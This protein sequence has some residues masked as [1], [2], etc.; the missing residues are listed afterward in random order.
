MDVL[1]T[2]LFGPY[3]HGRR[4]RVVISENGERSRRTFAVKSEAM[5]FAAYS[6][7]GIARRSDEIVAAAAALEPAKAGGVYAAV[8][9]QSAHARQLKAGFTT[10]LQR[11][12]NEFRTTNPTAAIAAIW[13]GDRGDESRAHAAL[14]GRIGRS[15]VFLVPNTLKALD[16]IERAIG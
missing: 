13:D 14:P 2:R 6:R 8:L 11:R 3:R 4:W 12:L 1:N 5:E 16:R 10:A 15:E 9:V 7:A